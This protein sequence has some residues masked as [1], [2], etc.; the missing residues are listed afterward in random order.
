MEAHR[1]L[2][3]KHWQIFGGEK[4]DVLLLECMDKFH[5]VVV[6]LEITLLKYN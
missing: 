5:C 1:H 3:L 6:D 2:L 4:C